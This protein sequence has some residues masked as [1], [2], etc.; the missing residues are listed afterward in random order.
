MNTR[1]TGV[2]QP[3]YSPI[4]N[5]Y[6]VHAD[7]EKVAAFGPIRDE[8]LKQAH[9][10]VEVTRSDLYKNKV[11]QIIEVCKVQTYNGK[12]ETSFTRNGLRKRVVHEE[13][14]T[15]FEDD[16]WRRFYKPDYSKVESF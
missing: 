4:E 14:P 12:G 11:L 5:W 6:E 13:H 16:E 3:P 9:E 10:L 2:N 1:I 8:A 15:V 7:Y